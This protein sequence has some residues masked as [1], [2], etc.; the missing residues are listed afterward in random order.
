MVEYELLDD[1]V[2]GITWDGTGYGSDGTIWGGGFLLRTQL[3]TVAAWPAS[4]R[5]RC[6]AEQ[7][8]CANRGAWLWRLFIRQPVRSARPPCVSPALP[9]RTSNDSCNYWPGLGCGP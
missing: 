6:R 4:G 9:S 3:P 1:E 8:Q 2:L 5:S 7:S